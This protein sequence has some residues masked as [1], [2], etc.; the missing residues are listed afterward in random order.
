MPYIP[1]DRRPYLAKPR[2]RK[3]A[4]DAGELNFQVTSLILDYLEDHTISYRTINDIVGALECAKAEFQR[5]VVG[6]YESLK[7]QEN[8]DVYGGIG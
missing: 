4:D 2:S 3:F 7:M 6:P 8:G 5:R 1:K